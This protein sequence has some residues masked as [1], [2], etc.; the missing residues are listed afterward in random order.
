MEIDKKA[1]QRVRVR[2]RRIST[3][4]TASALYLVSLLQTQIPQLKSTVESKS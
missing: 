3:T 2:N 1:K 4:P